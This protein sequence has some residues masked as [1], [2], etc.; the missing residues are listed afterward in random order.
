MKNVVSIVSGKP[1][2]LDFELGIE[3]I[4]PKDIKVRLCIKTKDYHLSFKCKKA[5]GKTWNCN[6]PALP[7][8]EKSAYPFFMEVIADGYHFNAM[9][10]T[11]NVTGSFD[12]YAKK[13]EKVKPGS[14]KK[15]EKKVENKP[16][17]KKDPKVEKKTTKESTKSFVD[18]GKAADKIFE[19][20]K[21]KATVPT[22]EVQTEVNE[23]PV[24]VTANKK[25]DIIHSIINETKNA[26]TTAV[27]SSVKRSVKK[28]IQKKVIESKIVPKDKKE[29]K[30]SKVDMAIKDILESNPTEQITRKPNIIDFKKGKVV[31][32]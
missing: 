20:F 26:K 19:T 32:R 13:S 29:K 25:D 14:E 21:K 24:A 12:I 28:K 23:E 5:K 9:E 6:I 7:H 17:T 4:N 10:G 27:A 3:G 31:Q 2:S 11:A 15:E 1:T 8:L 22:P 30:P 18:I 16:V